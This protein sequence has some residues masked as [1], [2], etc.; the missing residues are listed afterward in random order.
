ME[1]IVIQGLAYLII[2]VI[3]I[4]IVQYTHIYSVKKTDIRK[5][6]L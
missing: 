3:K 4:K 5:K 1:I 6:M 2:P